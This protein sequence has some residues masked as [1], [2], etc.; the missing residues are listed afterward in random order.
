MKN[1]TKTWEDQVREA[2]HPGPA[3]LDLREAL[4]K[5]ARSHTNSTWHSHL[6]LAAATLLLTLS[7]FGIWRGFGADPGP[8][9]ARQAYARYLEDKDA[10]FQSIS[11]CGQAVCSCAQDCG[12]AAWSKAAVGF[13]APLPTGLSERC[14]QGGRSCELNRKTVAVYLLDEKRTLYVF[15]TPIRKQQKTPLK[16]LPLDDQIQAR[17]WN[18]G[19]RGYLM[20]EGLQ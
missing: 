11:C 12:C 1:P 15:P 3:P 13:E 10:P 7:A 19:G 20:L 14:V 17:I 6:L 8:E 4:T 2:L 5:E 16:A 18:E 9:L